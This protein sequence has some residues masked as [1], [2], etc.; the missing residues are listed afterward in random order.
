MQQLAAGLSALNPALNQFLADRKTEYDEKEFQA[1]QDAY[2]KA[3][4]NLKDAVNK[5][6]IDPGYSPAFQRGYQQGQLRLMGMDY[7]QQLRQAY[8]TSDAANSTD[9]NAFQNFVQDFTHK[10]TQDKVAS[11][12]FDPGDIRTAFTPAVD[13]AQRSLGQFHVE[14]QAK[15]VED[16]WETNSQNE[17]STTIDNAKANGMSSDQIGAAVNNVITQQ[18]SNGWHDKKS[19]NANIVKLIADKAI[20]SGDP[21]L[22]DVMQHIP[23]GP[24][25]N[26]GNTTIARSAALEAQQ[27]ILNI[28][29]QNQQWEWS[30]QDHAWSAQSHQWAQQEH[31]HTQQDWAI[32]Q[33][34]GTLMRSMV[35]QAILDPTQDFSKAAVALSKLDRDG[36]HARTFEAFR[37]SQL[38][39][40]TNGEDNPTV[41]ASMYQDMYAHP[42]TFD[43][44]RIVDAYTK[45]NLKQKTFTGMLDDQR[46]IAEVGDSPLLKDQVYQT[47]KNGVI[48]AFAGDPNEFDA[49]KV[50]NTTNAAISFERYAQQYL[51]QHKGNVNQTEFYDAMQKYSNMLTKPLLDAEKPKPKPGQAKA[52]P[53]NPYAQSGMIH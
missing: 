13:M 42:Q 41:V 38:D 9:P 12:G 2:T 29:R 16:N 49:T 5:G 30:Q 45:G 33:S 32:E 4:S 18:M 6:V 10:Y 19:Y 44:T 51:Q 11:G 3:K 27:H 20:G 26:L 23:T 37:Q 25:G 46:R 34:A 43:P 52:L 15:T 35:A 21:S 28:K 8:G 50:T 40:K 17:I 31:A 53:A 14:Q 36:S 7:D 24:G 47:M 1:G 39:N 48:K 22:L